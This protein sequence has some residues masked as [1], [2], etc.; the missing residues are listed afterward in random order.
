MCS[1]LELWVLLC[2]KQHFKPPDNSGEPDFKP[3]AII[4]ILSYRSTHKR[5]FPQENT[6]K[7]GKEDSSQYK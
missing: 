6:V 4:P 2:P 5:Y 7:T 3:T 1:T